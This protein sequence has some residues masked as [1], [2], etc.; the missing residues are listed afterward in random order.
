MENEKN[1][2]EVIT[3][4]LL[5]GKIMIESGS[6]MYRVED[7]M[8]RIAKKMG[9]NNI[10]VFGTPTAIGIGFDDE[11][12]FQLK[13]IKSR[14]INLEKVSRVND[15]SRKFTQDIIDSSEL[16]TRLKVIDRDTLEF[17]V[18]LQAI[19]AAVVS[20]TLMILFTREYD[21]IDFPISAVIGMLGFF[22]FAYINE[23]TKLKFIS[24]FLS[25]IIVGSLAVISVKIGL[26]VKLDN[27]LIGAI[28][29]LVPGVPLTNSLR[30]L[31]ES[32][33]LAGIARGVEAILSALAIGIG[34]AVILKAFG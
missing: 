32:H 17:P 19:S 20:S 7:T 12:S 22:L 9:M 29:P 16:Y 6:E 4:C 10:N 5:A 27:I 14:S 13:Q 1:V 8:F 33:L 28:M 23:K 31:L 11:S 18:W 2:Q 34:I 24:E 25:S 30:D 21:W 26:G 15:V 3:T